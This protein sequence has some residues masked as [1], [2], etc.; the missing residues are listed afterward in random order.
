MQ[1]SEHFG[2]PELLMNLALGRVAENPF[3]EKDIT[4]LKHEINDDLERAGLGLNRETGHQ[5]DVPIDFRCS[6]GQRKIQKS[7]WT[8]LTRRPC[9]TIGQNAVPPRTLPTEEKMEV[10]GTGRSLELP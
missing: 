3:C 1:F 4:K 5:Q 9:W 2:T 7:D 8:V 10:S 6:C